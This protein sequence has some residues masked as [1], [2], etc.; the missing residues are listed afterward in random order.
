ML[1]LIQEWYEQNKFDP[2]ILPEIYGKLYFEGDK[3]LR[4]LTNYVVMLLLATVISTYG[5]TSDSTATVIGAMLVAPLMT[6]IMGV[7]LALVTGKEDRVIRSLVL[8]ILSVIAVIFFS[9]I[10]S[11]P[12]PYLDFQENGEIASR[13]EPGLSALGVALAAGAAGAFATSRKSVGDSLPGVAISIS[14]VPPLSVAGI[15]LSQARIDDG[16]G[17]FLLFFTNFLFINCSTL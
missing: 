1:D 2:S 5:V 15:A 7:T 12:I 14:L 11:F 8:V 10:L 13:V 4:K 16:F 3:R 9:A 6:P 17:A